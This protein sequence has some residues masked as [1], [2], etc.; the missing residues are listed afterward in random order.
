M[1]NRYKIG[2][3]RPR[4]PLAIQMRYRLRAWLADIFLLLFGIVAYLFPFM[5]ILNSWIGLNENGNTIKQSN[6]WLFKSLGWIILLFG[7]CGFVSF[8][9]QAPQLPADAA[10]IIGDLLKN[11]LSLLFNKMGSVL[12]LSTIVLWGITLV[13]GLSWLGIVDF[14][15][16]RVY[17]CLI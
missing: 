5:I 16:E 14:I 2:G 11:G 8:Y 17:R 7:S 10:G 1:K 6:E 9:I 4:R 15:G 13:T 12:L 3:D